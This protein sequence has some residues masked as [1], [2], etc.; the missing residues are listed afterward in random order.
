MASIAFPDIT[1]IAAALSGLA[2]A[3]ED[4]QVC[5]D[6]ACTYDEAAQNYPNTSTVG[7]RRPH[8]LVGTSRFGGG[9]PLRQ[10]MDAFAVGR[11]VS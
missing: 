6:E 1:G 10:P 9:S 4:G 8:N 5:P 7:E 2:E 11:L 3:V